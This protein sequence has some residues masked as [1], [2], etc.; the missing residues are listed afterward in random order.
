MLEIGCAIGKLCN[1][2][3]TMGFSYE[4]F[5]AANGKKI[6]PNPDVMS[7]YHDDVE[8]CSDLQA[9][10]ILSNSVLEHVQ[11]VDAIIQALATLTSSNGV[12]IHFIDLRDHFFKYPFEM[13]C[14]SDKTWYQWLNPS[15]HLNRCR[16]ADYQH[17][18]ETYFTNVEITVLESDREAFQQV[19]PRIRQ[20]FLSGITE[21]DAATVIRV[22]TKGTRR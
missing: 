8:K 12:Q 11:D 20:E 21:I 3:S 18:F 6:L 19:Q 17:I 10:L 9:D 2:L 15:S 5:L 14:Y 16:M 7:L 1:E 4:K 22:V 13:L